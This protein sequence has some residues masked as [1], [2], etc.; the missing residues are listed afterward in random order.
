MEGW[1]DGK[2]E[3]FQNGWREG[4]KMQMETS[5]SVGAGHGAQGLGARD[6]QQKNMYILITMYVVTT[7]LLGICLWHRH[8]RLLDY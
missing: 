7:Q 5:R 2:V 3:G 8:D 1:K 4:R 6:E